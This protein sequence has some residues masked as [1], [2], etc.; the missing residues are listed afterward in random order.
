MNLAVSSAGIASNSR[1]LVGHTSFA[2]LPD[3]KPIHCF[4]LT[5]L[6]QMVSDKY[7]S[8]SAKD[9]PRPLN[10]FTRQ[11][12]NI[13]VVSDPAHPLVDAANIQVVFKGHCGVRVQQFHVRLACP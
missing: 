12:L 2:V 9:P 13:S 8:L 3:V 6:S 1:G 7:Q 11:G 5:L 4:G 10:P